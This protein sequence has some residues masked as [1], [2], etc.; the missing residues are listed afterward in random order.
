MCMGVCMQVYSRACVRACAPVCPYQGEAL[1]RGGPPLDGGEGPLLH[2]VLGLLLHPHHR[3]LG[4]A[5]QP[6]NQLVLA[7]HLLLR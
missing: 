6:G 4:D 7:L 5:K 1:G 2:H 3:L